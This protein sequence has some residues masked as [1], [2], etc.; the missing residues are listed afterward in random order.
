MGFSGGGSD[1]HDANTN[2]DNEG[3]SHEVSNRYKDSL[4]DLG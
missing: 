2:M 4:K 1:N 3:C